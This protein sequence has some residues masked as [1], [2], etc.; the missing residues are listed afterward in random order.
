MGLKRAIIPNNTENATKCGENTKQSNGHLLVPFTPGINIPE[1][2]SKQLPRSNQEYYGEHEQSWHEHKCAASEVVYHINK[3][4]EGG[5]HHE[6]GQH[7]PGFH[8]QEEQ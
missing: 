5:Q 8:C 1:C 3:L 6:P 7:V 4:N 2:L